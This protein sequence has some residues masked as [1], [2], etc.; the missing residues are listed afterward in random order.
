[1]ASVNKVFL[2]GNLGADP[3]VRSTADGRTLCTLSVATSRSYKDRDGQRQKE[4]EW[5]RVVVFGRTAEVARDYLAKGSNVW[6]EGRLRTRKW[7][8]QAGADHYTT[9]IICEAMQLG[10]RRDSQSGSAGDGFESQP[11]PRPRPA[12]A[13]APVAASS[14]VDDISEDVPF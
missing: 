5:H 4:T 3:D 9:E 6:I 13:A 10:S 12:A 7:T 1:M 14:P 11:R 2:L 8:D